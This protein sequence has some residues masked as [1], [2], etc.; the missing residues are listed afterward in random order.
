MNDAGG[1][2]VL[3]LAYVNRA[4]FKFS[5]QDLLQHILR[6]VSSIFCTVLSF[7]SSSG[8]ETVERCASW[9]S[10]TPPAS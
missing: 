3:A 4:S 6:A 10:I 8:G 5:S 2:Q 9:C 7:L 1:R